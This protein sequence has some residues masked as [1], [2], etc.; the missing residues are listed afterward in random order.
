MNFKIAKREFMDVLTLQ[1]RALASNTPLP[2]LSGIK[3][4]DSEDALSLTSSDSN[5]SIKTVLKVGDNTTLT[6]LEEGEIVIESKYLFE[7]VRKI[8]SEL[9]SIEVMDGTLTKISGGNSE[10]KINGIRDF[11]YPEINFEFTSGYPFKLDTKLF[12]DII[13][14]TS[15]ACSDKEIRPVLTGVNMKAENG[16]LHVNATDSFRLAS[17]TVDVDQELKFNITVPAKYL[18]DVLHSIVGEESI[19]IIIDS[20]KICFL[21]KNSRIQTRLLDDA[22]PDTAKLLAGTFTQV[23]TVNSKNLINAVDR[24]S[25]IKSD[26]KNIV[27]LS[28]NANQIDITCSSQMGSSYEKID[29]ISYEGQPLNISCS[30]K[31]LI[32]ALRAIRSDVAVISFNGELRPMVIKPDK[33]SDVV[34]LIS[35]V[36]TYR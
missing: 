35:P 26:G 13:E 21:F 25:F 19:S 33:D 32:D 14:Q 6:I 28:I 20:Q 15:F 31:Y 36:R 18:S 1:A 4:V 7:I 23:L 2:A 5:I 3:I 22:F 34:Q 29:V 30:G 12:S 11:E 10:F 8:D 9:I 17:K 27:R 16:K 24:S